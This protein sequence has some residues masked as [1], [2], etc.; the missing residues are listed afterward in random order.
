[1]TFYDAFPGATVVLM[2]RPWQEIVR[3]IRAEGN[4]YR[5][6]EL[7]RELERAIEE[8]Q[9]FPTTPEP[10]KPAEENEAA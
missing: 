1:M 10:Q 5:R 8:Q 2:T 9:P 6:S 4:P 7:G 3:E